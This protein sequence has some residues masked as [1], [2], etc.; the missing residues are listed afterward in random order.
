MSQHD[1]DIANAAGAGIRADINAALA[2]L[3]SLNSGATEPATKFA[4][5]WW[6]DTTSGLLKRRNAANNA[7]IS[8][9][10]LS[11]GLIVGADVEAF[12]GYASQAEA[13][14]GAENTKIMTA[15]RVAQAIAALGGGG[16]STEPPGAYQPYAGVTLPSGYLWCDGAAV[17]RATYAALY[18][19]LVASSAVTLTIASPCVVSWT[20][21]PLVA[22]DPVKFATTGALPTGLVAG[23][24][25]YVKSPATD[26]FNVSATPGGAAIN[27]SGTQSGT[28]TAIHA[29]HGDGDGSTTFNTPD[30]R[31][32]SPVGRDDLGGTAANRVTAAG[33]GINGNVPGA[34]GGA[35]TVSLTSAQNGAHT[36]TTTCVNLGGNTYG[37]APAGKSLA[38][39]QST[40]VTSSSSGSGTAHQNM[41]PSII[42]K[43]IIKT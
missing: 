29:P 17:S 33:S 11:A 6:A 35:E 34:P 40:A 23:T 43:Y 31:G 20:A 12:H 9:M 30:L 8:V 38:S 2:A 1:Y 28:H 37:L 16:G 36:H 26:S 14:A 24:T 39:A 42:A 25:Y 15:L 21:H 22:N 19:A 18:G 5:Q 41:Q 27:T 10:S 4:Y 3:V 13:E 32:R 7:W